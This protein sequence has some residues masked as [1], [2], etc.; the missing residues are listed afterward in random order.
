MNADK[1]YE[2]LVNLV[3]SKGSLR[4]DRTG[5]GTLSVFGVQQHYDI[6]HSFPLITSKKVYWKGVVEELLW[7]LNGC[8][9]AEILQSKK[10]HIWDGNS[11][12]E[13]LD[14]LGLDY[15]TGHLGPVYGHQWRHFNAAYSDAE[16]DYTDCGVDQIKEI[17]NL[18]R[19]DP[20]SRRIILSAWNPGQNKLMALPACHTL[21][22]FYVD[23]DKLS[24]QLYQRSADIGLGVPFN[25]ASYSLLTYILAKMTGLVPHEFIHTIGDA[26]IYTNHIEQLKSQMEN[27]TFKSPTVNV[28][29]K[30]EYIEQYTIDDFELY[31]YNYS[32]GQSMKM[33]V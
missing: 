4:K 30:K 1:N 13:F 9:N 5:V 28:K 33:A 16:T 18:L 8:T 23:G 20:T 27:D 24:C 19:T 14:S 3:I 2:D 17:L 29:V 21:A 32:K 31:D 15:P 22:Q 10:V 26:H 7:M 11:S 25:I 12:R 6:S